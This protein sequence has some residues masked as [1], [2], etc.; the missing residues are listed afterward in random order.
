MLFFV[1]EFVIR[2][3][4]HFF[5]AFSCGRRRR[6]YMEQASC[7]CGCSKDYPWDGKGT[8]LDI[9][10]CRFSLYPMTNDFVSIILGA[11]EKTDT[12]AVWSQSDALSTVYRGKLEYVAD[13]VRGLF[14]N[15]WKPDVHMALEGQFSK[16]CPGDTDGDSLLSREGAAPN[17]E[18]IRDQHFPVLCKIALYP[19]KTENYLD[20]IAKVWR[21]AEE[22]GLNPTTIHYATRISG[23]VHQVFDYLEAV[24]RLMEQSV[25]HYI[26]HFT[27][28]VNSPT[29]E[30]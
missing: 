29:N 7:G 22:A 4:K 8:N 5:C 19:M 2:E 20:E 17:L 13:A 9:S 24:C 11:L 16:G 28:S 18:K 10:G 15:A 23:D 25:P 21:M 12:T 1:N 14:V 26:L 3:K 6:G 30:G 27:L